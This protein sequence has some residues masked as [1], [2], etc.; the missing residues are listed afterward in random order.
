[1]I[2]FRVSGLLRLRVKSERLKG[3]RFEWLVG[4][5]GIPPKRILNTYSKGP[6]THIV[7]IWALKLL[8]GNPFKAQVY[9]RWVH[10]A[11]GIHPP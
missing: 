1:M 9:T 7:Y 11:F 4:R 8:Y 2:G 6:C 5:S 10:G 3:K